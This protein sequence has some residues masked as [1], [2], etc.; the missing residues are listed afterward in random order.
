MMSGLTFH[1]HTITTRALL[2][3]NTQHTRHTTPV[4]NHQDE[5]K[6]AVIYLRQRQ[7][8][9]HTAMS[10]SSCLYASAVS[11]ILSRTFPPPVSVSSPATPSSPPCS[12][13][14]HSS[15]PQFPAVP[16]SA[17]PPPPPRPTAR[18]SRKMFEERGTGA[19]VLLHLHLRGE[20]YYALYMNLF[21]GTAPT[22]PNLCSSCSAVAPLVPTGHTSAY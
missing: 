20:M 17:K 18:Q 1:P 9:T 15:A 19:L 4:N 10:S 6:M 14:A 3:H 22:R 16:P 11:P 21:R 13:P 5:V 7:M 2:Q 8:I 12:Q